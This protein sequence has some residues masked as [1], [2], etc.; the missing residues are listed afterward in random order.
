MTEYRRPKRSRLISSPNPYLSEGAK[1]WDGRTM[2]ALDSGR[3][4]NSDFVPF[5]VAAWTVAMMLLAK[6]LG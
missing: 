5:I 3:H 4:D 2:R 1:D 6:W